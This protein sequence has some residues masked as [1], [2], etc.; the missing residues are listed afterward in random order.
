MSHHHAPHLLPGLFLCPHE[1]GGVR[2]QGGSPEALGAAEASA[3]G[4]PSP[5]RM[6]QRLHFTEEEAESMGGRAQGKSS[7]P[8]RRSFL[9]SSLLWAAKHQS[10]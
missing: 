8:Q 3:Q 10:P 6:H 9:L 1:A 2:Q 4:T 5:G 7:G